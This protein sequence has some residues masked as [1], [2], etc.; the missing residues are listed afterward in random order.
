VGEG[1][2]SWPLRGDDP[3]HG[4]SMQRPLSFDSAVLLLL[5][6]ALFGP[7]SWVHGVQCCLARPS[8]Q[9]I[10]LTGRR[11]GLT[12]LLTVRVTR[13]R[14]TC[15]VLHVVSKPCSAAAL[16]GQCAPHHFCHLSMAQLVAS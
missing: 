15:D 1:H 7:V 2:G 6:S 11:G 3:L 16:C 4:Q 8:A 10:D 12:P 13:E 9:L 14:P 5:L